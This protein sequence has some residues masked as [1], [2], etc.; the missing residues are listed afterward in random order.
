MDFFTKRDGINKRRILALWFARLP[1]DR[2]QRKNAALA[3]RPLAVSIRAGNSFQL[4]AV[5][6]M[7]QARGLHAGQPLANARAMVQ[8]L[9]VV[10][11]DR[12]A[13]AKLLEDLADWCDYFS[14][15][16]AL[17][18]SDGLLLDISGGAHLF[19]GEAALLQQITARI[20]RQGFTVGGAIAGTGP[21]ARA[22]ARFANG[23]IATPQQEIES[24]ARLPVAALDCTHAIR[25]GLEQ[26]GLKNIGQVLARERSELAA[27]FGK[28][29]VGDLD[30]LL[31]LHDRPINPRH[32]LPDLMAEQRFGEPIVTSAAILHALQGLVHNLGNSLMRRGLGLRLLEAAFF[33]ADGAVRR[34][35]VQLGAP[36]R[37]A[38]LLMRLLEEKLEALADPLDPGF[39]YDLIRL[40]AHLGEALESQEARLDDDACSDQ[41]IGFLLDRL[42]TRFGTSRVLRLVAQDTHI[43]EA[44]SAA[45]PAQDRDMESASWT[46]RRGPDDPPLRPLRL[47]QQPEEISSVL[48]SVPDGPPARFRWRRALHEVARAEG[49]ERIALEWWQG[50]AGTRDYFRVETR[51]GQRFW[52]YRDGLSGA[53]WYLQGLFA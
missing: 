42:S 2:L 9:V 10:P 53:R 6:Q 48:A 22:L 23:H 28:I 8:S 41:Q 21:A 51:Q 34:L 27:R 20:A 35:T 7:A 3:E 50:R 38:G 25:H 44:A 37:D 30:I 26:A 39:G 29:F 17:D 12:K 31:G 16:V 36:M 5:N 1:T 19:G 46:L 47:L 40:D 43:P 18:G 32:P 15:F 4:H 24:L 33:R 52:L 45:I 13:D 14:P 49:P 11:A